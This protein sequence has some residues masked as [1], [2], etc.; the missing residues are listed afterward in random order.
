MPGP[1]R[2]LHVITRMI[3]G[4][5]QENTLLSVEGLD[6]YPG[7]EVTLAS[8]VDNGP[9]GDLLDRTRK[10]TRLV[11]VPELGRAVSP[12]ND[13]TALRKLYR[14]I[15]DG[16]YHVVHTHSS[17]AGVLGRVA[18]KL[19]G[20]PVIV[21]TL[22]SLVFHDYQP[23]VV[24]RCW[25][26]MKKLCAPITDHFISVSDVIRQKAIA[27]GIDRPEKFTTVYSG[28]ELDWFLNARVDPAAV[29]REFGIPPEAPV[30][31]KIARLFPLK[32]HDQLLDAAPAV[33]KRC[34]DVRFFLVGDGILYDRLRRRAEQQGI[35]RN[36]IFAGL[37]VRERIPEMLAA[38]DVVVHTSLR[39][40][41]AR[42][43]PQALAM[44]K[45][46]VSFDIDGAPEVVIPGETGYLVRPG[47][48]AG[49]AD[50]LGRLLAD[51]GLR[52]RMGEAG[53]RVV[54]PAFR[55]ET[56]VEQIAAVYATLVE[57][58]AAR[59]ARFDRRRPPGAADLPAA[60]GHS[61]PAVPA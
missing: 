35:L 58:H 25:W 7:Y 9:E 50:A 13:A 29:R 18:A 22:H 5:A 27:A 23:W 59:I 28:M 48:A 14:L 57:R 54:D 56:M 42:V 3:V 40:G 26:G 2:V 6:R 32:G 51:P 24:N 46:C 10:T 49:L 17:K 11:I 47:D 39:E 34:P 36:F 37:I 33:V 4:G 52:A 44:G 45:P 53:R 41:L 60:A 19:A 21:H 31:G 12:V 38:M 16:R 55:A 61:A 1:I 8:G 15:R 20:T 30:V 43:L